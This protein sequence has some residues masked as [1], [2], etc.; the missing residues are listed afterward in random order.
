MIDAISG[1]SG[2]IELP[3]P[4]VEKGEPELVNPLL[5]EAVEVGAVFLG[6]LGAQLIEDF[7]VHLQRHGRVLVQD[8]VLIGLVHVPARPVEVPE[9]RLEAVAVVGASVDLVSEEEGVARAGLG[10]L[11][12]FFGLAG[13]SANVV[14][15]LEINGM[16]GGTKEC[17]SQKGDGRDAQASPNHSH[18]RQGTPPWG[19]AS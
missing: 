11:A 17:N 10:P 15:K 19:V 4:I 12:V 16:G 1:G 5:E 9:A 7:T 18:S 14:E 2:E 6:V 13:L 8:L 3:E